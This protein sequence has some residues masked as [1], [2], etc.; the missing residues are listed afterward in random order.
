MLIR[1]DGYMAW[2]ADSFGPAQEPGL[3]A[4]LLRWFGLESSG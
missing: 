3:R 2:A 4:A 1:P